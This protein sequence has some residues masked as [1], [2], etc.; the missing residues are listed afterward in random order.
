MMRFASPLSTV[1]WAQPTGCTKVVAMHH[2]QVVKE[3]CRR[4]RSRWWEAHFPPGFADSSS[5]ALPGEPFLMLFLQTTSDALTRGAQ[6]DAINV[7]EQDDQ[8]QGT[9]HRSFGFF[10]RWRILKAVRFAAQR[11]EELKRATEILRTRF[12]REPTELELCGTLGL[13]PNLFD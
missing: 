11:Q 10:E 2:K 8:S 3:V 7:I 5:A 1:Q 13:N 12:G 9:E 6:F 4:L